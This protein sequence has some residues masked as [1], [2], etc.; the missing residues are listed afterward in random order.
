[1]IRLTGAVDTVSALLLRTETNGG[2]QA[3]DG[4]L[5]LLLLGLS[6]RVVDGLEVADGKSYEHHTRSS[7]G[8]RY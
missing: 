5:R 3:N 1:M 6:N 2:L 8:S 4:G 7:E